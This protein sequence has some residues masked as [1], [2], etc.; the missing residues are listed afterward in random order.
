M[1]RVTAMPSIRIIYEDDDT[2]TR[3]CTISIFA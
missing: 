3:S 2:E 1:G